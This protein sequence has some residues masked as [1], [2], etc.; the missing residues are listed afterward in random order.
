[1]L[2]PIHARIGTQ[3]SDEPGDYSQIA[4]HTFSV[5]PP[6]YGSPC[7]LTSC[8]CLRALRS[9]IHS[10]RSGR[11]TATRLQSGPNSPREGTVRPS[12]ALGACPS[13]ADSFQQTREGILPSLGARERALP[14]RGL[15]PTCAI[16]TCRTSPPVAW[17][18]NFVCRDCGSG[19]PP[20]VYD[21]PDHVCLSRHTNISSYTRRGHFA[22][23]RRCMSVPT[24]KHFVLHSP[25]TFRTATAAAGKPLPTLPA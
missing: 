16:R 3:R 25:W 22:Q 14:T 17:D 9:R 20:S 2:G 24:H 15:P 4:P 23:R 12:A 13:G 1:M 5:L 7:F 11:R 10:G 18:D 6:R 19:H 8:P 21:Q